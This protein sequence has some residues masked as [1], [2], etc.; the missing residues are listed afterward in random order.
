[1]DL[2]LGNAGRSAGG[3]ARNTKLVWR[4]FWSYNR[5][6]DDWAQFA[7]LRAYYGFMWGWPGKKL[8]FMGQEFAQRE[9]WSEARGLDWWLLEAPAHEGVRRL[10]TDLN[11]LYPELPA[12]HAR[13]LQGQSA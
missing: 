9:E 6:T 1:M 3:G 4:G 13:V 5:L 12:L 8:L 7:G 10:V 2:S 11:A